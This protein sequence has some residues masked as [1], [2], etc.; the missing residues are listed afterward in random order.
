MLPESRNKGLSE[1]FP[2][3][4]YVSDVKKC[5]VATSIAARSPAYGKDVGSLNEH[6]IC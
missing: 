4:R 1:A 6:L 5:K 3:F 2:I